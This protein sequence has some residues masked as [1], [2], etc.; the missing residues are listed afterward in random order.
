MRRLFQ[1]QSAVIGMIMLGGLV[2]TAIFA[3][4]IAPYEPTQVLIGIEPVKIR[5]GP[6]IHILGCPQDHP[7]HLMNR[8][9]RA[10]LFS[11][12]VYGSRVSW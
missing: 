12:V 2:V 8:R 1:R 10:D 4:W 3:P 6:C 7:Q 9:K 11:R 5:E